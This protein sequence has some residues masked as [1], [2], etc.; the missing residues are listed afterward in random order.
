MQ[1]SSPPRVS[2][3]SGQT[4]NS[5]VRK[6][7][8]RPPAIAPSTPSRIPGV[9]WATQGPRRSR[10]IKKKPPQ[11]RAEIFKHPRSTAQSQSIP[12]KTQTQN[13][14]S[15]PSVKPRRSIKKARKDSA[16][17]SGRVITRSRS[18]KK[19]NQ[20]SALPPHKHAEV[21]RW[22]LACSMYPSYDSSAG[23]L[24]SA[25][26]SCSSSGSRSLTFRPFT[27]VDDLT[28]QYIPA[29][30]MLLASSDSGSEWNLI[31]KTQ[32]MPME[33]CDEEALLNR[34]RSLRPVRRRSTRQ[35]KTRINVAPLISEKTQKQPTQSYRIDRAR[36]T[37]SNN[38]F[39]TEEHVLDPMEFDNPSKPILV[40]RSNPKSMED[41][42]ASWQQ[43]IRR[44]VKFLEDAKAYYESCIET[45]INDF[46]SG[47]NDS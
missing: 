3:N 7:P 17:S 14:T 45:W 21:S 4:I 23:D 26:M 20:K 29:V 47:S 36:G 40:V 31:S 42:R 13:S 41:V 2:A 5:S 33:E 12:S 44:T 9:I 43:D 32:E 35:L 16:I 39:L 10:S 37:L 34:G 15:Q 46:T 27:P 30:E 11:G 28:E 25:G 24:S 19:R 18:I 22:T 8:L 1:R 38:A 6:Q